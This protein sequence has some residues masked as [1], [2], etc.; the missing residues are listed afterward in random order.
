MKQTKTQPSILRAMKK[1]IHSEKGKLTRANYLR[2]NKP[3]IKQYNSDYFKNKRLQALTQ[4]ICIGCFKEKAREGSKQCEECLKKQKINRE[5]RKNA[6]LLKCEECSSTN[7][8]SYFSLEKNQYITECEDCKY[9]KS[10][11]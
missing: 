5:K 3:R 1:Y 2:T 9:W 4:N 8:Q 7:V 11:K 10:Q 6:P